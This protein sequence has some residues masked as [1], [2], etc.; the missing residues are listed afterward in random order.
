MSS[1]CIGNIC[2]SFEMCC[3]DISAEVHIFL[4]SVPDI[5][6]QLFCNTCYMVLLM[7]NKGDKVYKYLSAAMNLALV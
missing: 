1:T 6:A 2:A 4:M 5:M 3:V 7:Y